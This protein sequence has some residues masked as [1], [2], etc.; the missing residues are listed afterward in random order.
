MKS[1]SSQNSPGVR[2]V[3]KQRWGV[4]K[5]RA[6]G[7][8]LPSLY[9]GALSPPGP[10]KGGRGEHEPGSLT[11]QP[12]RE[13]TR[14]KHATRTV[15]AHACMHTHRDTAPGIPARLDTGNCPKRRTSQP[16][17]SPEHS[18][19]AT[20]TSFSDHCCRMKLLKSFKTKPR[21]H[22]LED[23][24]MPLRSTQSNWTE[25]QGY[26][27]PYS[28]CLDRGSPCGAGMPASPCL[29]QTR[30]RPKQ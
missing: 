7:P 19:G 26:S 17:G 10:S 12:R 5:L 22:T 29:T 8:L 13:G 25:K 1:Y 30:Q 2:V 27:C 18:T 3:A 11:E 24:G 23:R 21:G 4:G 15:Q 9:I 20:I 28:M 16:L 6:A 14:H